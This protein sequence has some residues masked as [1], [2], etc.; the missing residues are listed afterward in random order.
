MEFSTADFSRLSA[1]LQTELGIKLPESKRTMLAGRLHKRL[2]ALAMASF[3]TYCDF[4][5]SADGRKKELVHLLDAVTTNKT[6][7]FREPD[8]FNYLKNTVLPG[9][10]ARGKKHLRVWSAACSTGEEPYTLAMVLSEYQRSDSGFAFEILATDVCTRVLEVARQ[11]TYA[12]EKID[13]VPAE[14]RK[15]YLLKGKG[16]NRH[17]VRI[18]QEQRAR[19]SFGRL[20]FMAGDFR[21]PKMQHIIFCRN[22]LIYF[23][24]KT[25]EAV[26]NKL[27]Q[28]LEP[29][30]YLFLGHS[31][32]ILGYDVP[33][34]QE[35]PTVHRRLG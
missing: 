18:A 21:L 24:K 35:A 7:F 22:V 9:F 12:M 33:L 3:A 29:D 32:S 26:I 4:I 34:R 16:E 17:L 8:H 2:R 19:V 28:Y 30:G 1:Y 31:E 11:A 23:D 10:K 25:Q 6:D 5:F 13:P 14:Y 15:R 27:C 20:N